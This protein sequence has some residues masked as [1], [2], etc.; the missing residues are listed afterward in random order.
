VPTI[1]SL[2]PVISR[3]YPIWKAS[4]T[5]HGILRAEILKKFESSNKVFNNESLKRIV[6]SFRNKPESGWQ[7][8]PS[9][10]KDM[11]LDGRSG[12]AVTADQHR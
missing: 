12:N 3:R 2:R 7:F 9:Y 10:V 4:E 8:W 1:I 5:T 6:V 11:G